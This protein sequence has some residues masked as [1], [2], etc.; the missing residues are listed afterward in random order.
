M[1]QHQATLLAIGCI[2]FVIG[3]IINLAFDYKQ[4]LTTGIN[5]KNLSHLL[6]K[7]SI[8]MPSGV[9]LSFAI[10]V[11]TKWLWSIVFTSLMEMFVFWVV[12]DIILNILRSEK[13]Y[14]IGSPD[15]FDSGTEK[16][17]RRLPLFWT[18]LIKFALAFASIYAYIKLLD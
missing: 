16:M 11:H 4:I 3:L 17:E 7:A 6:R 2:L 10:A 1:S 13:W 8:M 12:F 5:H 9:I 18:W 15:K 14:Y